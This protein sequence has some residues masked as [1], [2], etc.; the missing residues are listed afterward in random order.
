MRMT[1]ALAREW[2]GAARVARL[3]TVTAAGEPHLVPVTFAVVA[4]DASSADRDLVVFAIDHK[5]KSTTALRRLDNIAANP[6]VAFLVDHYAEDW[7]Q[8]WWVRAD[9]TAE[10]LHGP[11]RQR[12]IAELQA[13]Y[14]QYQQLPPDGVVVGAAVSRWTGGQAS[15]GEA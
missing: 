9:A 7:V 12:G 11:V 3:G 5:P 14:P 4:A 15:P 8:L 13:K 2:F 6:A 10:V 1:S